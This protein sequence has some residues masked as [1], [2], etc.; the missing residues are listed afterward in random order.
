MN[1]APATGE[2]ATGERGAAGDGG[3]LLEAREL[4][5]A[6]APK[7]P[8]VVCGASLGLRRGRLAALI[9]ANGSGKSSLIRLL[10]GLVAP[11]RG[12]VVFDGVP[13][14]KIEPRLRARRIAY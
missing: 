6:Y 7:L 3:V 8:E 13:L 10:G 12:E 1:F 4:R 11:T 9:G 14:A 5:F 2:Q